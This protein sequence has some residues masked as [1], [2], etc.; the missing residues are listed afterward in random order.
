MLARLLLDTHVL[1]RWLGDA[2]KL[3]REQTRVI[4]AAL[5]NAE[6]LAVS[7]I[8]LLEIAV[9]AG[10]GKLRI[11]TSL[12]EFFEDLAG[13]P[14][15]RILPLNFD[16]ASDVALLSSLRD[17]ADRVIVASARVNRLRLVTSDQRIV[18]SNLV[19]VVD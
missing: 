6:P 8:S 4:D 7:A 5:R 13:N 19:P 15:F 10:D 16:V 3:S 9:L 2:G 14:V 17:P 12:E 1:L 18:G 11:K